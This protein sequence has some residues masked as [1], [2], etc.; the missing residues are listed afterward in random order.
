MG[1]G[2]FPNRNLFLRVLMGIKERTKKHIGVRRPLRS[3]PPE[4]QTTPATAL[5]AA[6]IANHSGKKQKSKK[7]KK[8]KCKNAKKQKRKKAKKAKKQKS[9]KAKKQKRKKAKQQKGI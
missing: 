3:P 9:K 4:S 5:A 7:A 8:Q 1:S 6:R 2:F